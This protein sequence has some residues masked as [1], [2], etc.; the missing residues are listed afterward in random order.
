[1]Y[2][3]DDLIFIYILVK[4]LGIED[5]LINLFGLMFYEII[6]F[7]LVKVDVSGKKLMDSFY[8]INLVGYIIYSVVYEVCYDVECVLYIYIVVGI[9]V[10]C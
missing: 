1:M 3:W 9:V 5:F 6:V 7:S 4:V 10:F 2:G 8:E